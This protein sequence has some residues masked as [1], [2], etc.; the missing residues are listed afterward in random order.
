LAAYFEDVRVV[1]SVV[2]PQ[3]NLE[4]L[5]SEVADVNAL[6]THALPDQLGAVDVQRAARQNHAIVEIHV[7]VGE[8]RGHQQIVTPHSGAQQQRPAAHQRELQLRKESRALVVQP[9]F[10]TRSRVDVAEIVEQTERFVVLQDPRPLWNR[11]LNGRNVVT[12]NG[13]GHALSWHRRSPTSS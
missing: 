8:I 9:L 13:F 7:R 3:R 4:R 1:G 6:I 11:D 12:L 2:Q 10:R 5:T